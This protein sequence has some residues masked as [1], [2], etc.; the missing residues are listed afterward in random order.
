M[1]TKED[2]EKKRAKIS[3][4]KQLHMEIEA[5]TAKNASIFMRI[6]FEA[7]KRDRDLGLVPDEEWDRFL[8]HYGAMRSYY[9][10]FMDGKQAEGHREF[11]RHMEKQLE[12]ME[13]EYRSQNS[14]S[15]RLKRL[16]SDE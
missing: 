6:D 15:N 7:A 10:A 2:L 13:K 12:E 4:I 16:F 14:I 11:E 1:V 9:R 8:F 5:E 3:E